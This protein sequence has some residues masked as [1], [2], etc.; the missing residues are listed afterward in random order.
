MRRVAS[1]SLL[2]GAVA[3]AAVALI[4]QIEEERTETMVQMCVQRNPEFDPDSIDPADATEVERIWNDPLPR[5][6]LLVGGIDQRGWARACRIPNDPDGLFEGEYRDR[7]TWYRGRFALRLGEGDGVVP[8]NALETHYVDSYLHEFGLL[9]YPLGSPEP[10]VQYLVLEPIDPDGFA[11]LPP[12][13][14]Q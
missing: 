12:I 10:P 6:L 2:V 1:I 13:E 4:R 7:H 11:A 3:V 5:D 9:L 14:N 8:E